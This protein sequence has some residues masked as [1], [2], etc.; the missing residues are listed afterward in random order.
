MNIFE[1]MID[2]TAQFTTSVTDAALNKLKKV[3]KLSDTVIDTGDGI[4]SN[5]GQGINKVVS[6]VASITNLFNTDNLPYYI[7]GAIVLIILLKKL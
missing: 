1:R 6:N 5:T 2:N 4:I 3:D 7:A